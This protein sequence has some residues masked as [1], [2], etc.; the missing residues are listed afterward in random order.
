MTVS[1]ALANARLGQGRISVPLTKPRHRPLGLPSDGCGEQYGGRPHRLEAVNEH[2]GG[3]Q[4][5]LAMPRRLA[6]GG[7]RQDTGNAAA[8]VSVHRGQKDAALAALLAP[9]SHTEF[10][11]RHSPAK[12]SA[13]NA[14]Y[15]GDPQRSVGRIIGRCPNDQGPDR[16]AEYDARRMPRAAPSPS[17]CRSSLTT[18]PDRPRGMRRRTVPRWSPSPCNGGAILPPTFNMSGDFAQDDAGADLKTTTS[19][20]RR[21]GPRARRTTGARR[22]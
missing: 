5:E 4:T 15:R 13:M 2:Q 20:R 7:D 9:L 1:W 8:R 14:F 17:S 11:C 12:Q 6:W 10:A 3:E 18:S 19:T 22:T 21:P 16:R